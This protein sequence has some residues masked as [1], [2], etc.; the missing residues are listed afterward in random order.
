M[1]QVLFPMASPAAVA[2]DH[3]AVAVAG[4]P[5]SLADRMGQMIARSAVDTQLQQETLQRAAADPAVAGN[6]AVLYRLQLA[7]AD[8]SIQL[9][10]SSTLAR[11]AVGGIETLIKA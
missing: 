5:Q 10:L 1:N 3:A 7:L 2:P 4:E 6:P 11:K 8:Y 9:N